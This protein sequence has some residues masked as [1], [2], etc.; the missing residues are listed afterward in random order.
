MWS[1]SNKDRYEICR[2]VAVIM[3]SLI[4]KKVDVI[5][6]YFFIPGYAYSNKTTS[7]Y[8]KARLE[9][10][11]NSVYRNLFSNTLLYTESVTLFHPGCQQHQCLLKL[12]RVI[13][14]C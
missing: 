3:S 8:V 13:R 7:A 9:A 11:L 2:F 4:L 14:E 5:F 1:L 6:L 10:V 12:Y